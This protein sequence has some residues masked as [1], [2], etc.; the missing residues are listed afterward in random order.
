MGSRIGGQ[1]SEQQHP[2]DSHGRFARKNL[3][4][5]VAARNRGDGPNSNTGLRRAL[6]RNKGNSKE[7]IAGRIK[8]L[9]QSKRS[10]VREKFLEHGPTS[11]LKSKLS[12]RL[13]ERMAT[14]NRQ[15]S[16][17]QSNRAQER[18]NK[19]TKLARIA[20]KTRQAE[21]QRLLEKRQAQE[22]RR[23]AR[24]NLLQTATRGLN[25]PQSNTGHRNFVEARPLGKINGRTMSH[26]KTN[27]AQRIHQI[28]GEGR[29]RLTTKFIEHGVSHR[30]K[31]NLQT[32]ER[33]RQTE[34]GRQARIARRENGTTPRPRT[35]AQRSPT[36]T[37][38]HPLINK[39]N[40]SRAAVHTT[41]DAVSHK[42]NTRSLPGTSH[43]DNQTRGKSRQQLKQRLADRVVALGSSTK[44]NRV[45]KQ[46]NQT[47]LHNSTYTKLRAMEAD[48]RT[49]LNNLSAAERRRIEQEQAMAAARREAKLHPQL[50]ATKR[51][52]ASH[53][54]FAGIASSIT[55]QNHEHMKELFS[56]VTPTE[57]HNLVM[58]GMPEGAHVRYELRGNTLTWN[59]SG[60]GISSMTRNMHLD[61]KLVYHAYFQVDSSVQGGGMGKSAFKGLFQLYDKVGIKHV[62]VTAN[63]DVGG[64]A[65][66]RYGFAP[67]NPRAIAQ[68]VDSYRQNTRDR[69]SESQKTHLETIS[70]RLHAGEA[71]AMWDLVDAK[72]PII[73]KSGRISMVNDKPRT[74][75]KSMLLGTNWSGRIDLTDP[76]N[77][78][79][80]HKYVGLI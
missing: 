79:R 67:K 62:D 15:A 65:W 6:S 59:A 29:Q 26:I 78:R 64:Y 54:H 32:K 33:A 76:E 35:A 19:A 2:R 34:L 73:L 23:Q 24:I 49:H 70:R 46:F 8:A 9:P 48:R 69:L 38:N 60:G 18:T 41:A 53:P 27:L 37:T 74:P 3:L 13:S 7:A 57:F 56:K 28:G 68:M 44:Q 50:A 40:R 12:A 42:A 80:T 36:Q 31:A 11:A 72:E 47:G 63:I 16:S 75:A 10:A 55:A 17:N 61:Q 45:I 4:R 1:F 22:Q 5:G 43:G 20:E 25:K 77:K 66:A 51:I 14:L 71:K 39:M 58:Q 30:L 52:A 21:Q